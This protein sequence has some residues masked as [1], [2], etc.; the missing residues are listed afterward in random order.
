V[1]PGRVACSPIWRLGSAGR[2]VDNGPRADR[3]GRQPVKASIRA[4]RVV[5]SARLV[6]PQ[7]RRRTDAAAADASGSTYPENRLLHC[8]AKQLLSSDARSTKTFF[9]V[10]Y[11]CS[12]KPRTKLSVSGSK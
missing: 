9:R 6:A 10:R 4:D 12:P 3:Q 5:G 8:N 2:L 11:I 1:R 7:G